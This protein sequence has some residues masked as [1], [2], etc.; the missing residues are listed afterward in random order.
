M[1]ISDF[2]KI[3]ILVPHDLKY[4]FKNYQDIFQK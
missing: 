2:K 4:I 1:P 3:E